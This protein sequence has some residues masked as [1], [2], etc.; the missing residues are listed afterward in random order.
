MSCE[1]CGSDLHVGLADWCSTRALLSEAVCGPCCTQCAEKQREAHALHVVNKLVTPEVQYE[2]WQEFAKLVYV[3]QDSYCACV[4]EATRLAVEQQQF[5]L[6]LDRVYGFMPELTLL[7]ARC[8]GIILWLTN[9]QGVLWCKMVAHLLYT[10][11]ARAAAIF[12]DVAATLAEGDD[13]WG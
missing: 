1:V 5:S 8:P 3:V 6:V 13:A 4:A 12:N 7:Q 2:S 10:R 11:V 9:R